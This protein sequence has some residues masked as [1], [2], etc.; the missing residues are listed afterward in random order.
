VPEKPRLLDTKKSIA[1]KASKIE[2]TAFTPNMKKA[3]EIE[4]VV[5]K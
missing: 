3:K 2:V 5:N 4:A 1:I